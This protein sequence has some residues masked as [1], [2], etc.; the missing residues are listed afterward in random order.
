MHALLWT[1]LGWRRFS[2]DLSRFDL[3][4][5]LSLNAQDRRELRVRYPVRL[6]LGVA[7]PLGFVRLPSEML[8]ARD[9]VPRAV[10]EHVAQ[11]PSMPAP[12]FA[13]VLGDFAPGESNFARRQLS[14]AVS[15]DGR[16]TCSFVAR[17]SAIEGAHV[18]RSIA[19]LDLEGP[20]A[21]GRAVRRC[22]AIVKN[23]T[24]SVLDATA[25]PRSGRSSH[26]GWGPTRTH[27]RPVDQR[28]LRC[29]AAA[30][31]A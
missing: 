14:W 12:E 17:A 21:P 5:F 19:P 26:T 25:R 30:D 29:C 1:Y 8:D 16:C 27:K 6:R 11:R 13:A 3:C 2:R 9:D 7:V 28:I 22:R 20:W 15:R 18:P 24:R 31:F 4:R 10:L 23:V